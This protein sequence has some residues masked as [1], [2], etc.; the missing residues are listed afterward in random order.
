MFL[1]HVHFE[2]E[3]VLNS[4]HKLQQNVFSSWHD[5]GYTLPPTCVC[6]CVFLF[7]VRD[8]R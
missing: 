5:N 4:P 3:P 1:L 8:A 6:V 2:Y 7:N